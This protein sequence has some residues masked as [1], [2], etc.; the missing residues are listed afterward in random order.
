MHETVVWRGT[1][2]MSLGQ[3]V[4]CFVHRKITFAKTKKMPV[5][6][7]SICLCVIPS[8]R[9]KLICPRH[10]GPRSFYAHDDPTPF[11][12]LTAR[13]SNSGGNGVLTD[14]HVLR[15]GQ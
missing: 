7:H 12:I 13:G 5:V 11:L 9:L 10:T 15:K 1:I 6:P 4:Y 14:L 3:S 8:V 2:K